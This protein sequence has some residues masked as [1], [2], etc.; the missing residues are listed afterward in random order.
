MSEDLKNKTIAE[1]FK[2]EDFDS[3]EEDFVPREEAELD[4]ALNEIADL[5]ESMNLAGGPIPYPASRNVDNDYGK[6]ASWGKTIHPCNQL[7]STR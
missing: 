3:Y 4:A 5:K 6:S 1:I 2:D 7:I